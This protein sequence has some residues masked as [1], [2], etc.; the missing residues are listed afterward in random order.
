MRPFRGTAAMTDTGRTIAEKVFSRQHLAGTPVRAGDLVD[1]RLDGLM[2]HVSWRALRAAY[3]RIGF[4]DGPPCVWDP[5][6]LFL[7]TEHRQP[8]TDVAAALAN[9]DARRDAQRLGIRHFYDAEMGIF[10]QMLV[11]YGHARPG[12]LLVGSDSHM[13][14]LGALNCAA[15][16]I[17]D[18]ESAY[19]LAFGELHFSVPETLR[20]VLN[21]RPRR[22]PFAKD[23]I[24]HLAGRFGDD[25]AQGRSLEFHGPLAHALPLAERFCLADHAVEVGGKFGLFTA[26]ALAIDYVRAR[27]DRPFVPVAPDPDAVYAGTLEVDCDALG[28][29]V[30]RPYRF[31][32]VVPVAAVAG[33]R[34]D[35]ARI[36]SC[37]NGRFEDIA[38]A[39][40]IVAGRRVAPGVRCY[41]SPASRGVYRACLE[42]GLLGT[43]ID[44][45]VQVLDPGCAICTTQV[46]LD[47]EVCIS[48]TTRNSRGR[49]G[50]P[51]TGDAQVYLAGPA[52]V[53]AAAVAGEIVDPTEFLGDQ[54]RVE[55]NG[56]R[57]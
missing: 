1:A 25:F 20:I 36:G 12:E 29:Q 33:T 13:V 3:R 24:L 48:S 45:G 22:Y 46:V 54:Y 39:A 37:A 47:G 44:A 32:N 34:I 31:D 10:S 49:F 53:A 51:E 27:S 43:L 57:Y 8:P 9:R 11:E 35:Q 55:I 2:V 7:M 23:I 14:M 5:E 40:R 18:D 38:V 21:G 16:G 26:D 6:R 17:G 52:T 56:S 19:A 50:G 4:V 42:A 15:T 28:F 30:A 41:V